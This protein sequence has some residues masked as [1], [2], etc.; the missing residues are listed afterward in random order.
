M[1]RMYQGVTRMNTVE[2]SQKS[3]RGM[4]RAILAGGLV[5]GVG[6]A[7]TLA[8]W[9]DSEFATGT[10]TAGSFNVQGT[11]G[12]PAATPTWADHATSAT[13]Q[14]LTFSL[15]LTN[16]TPGDTVYAPFSMRVDTTKNS[17]DATVVPGSTPVAITGVLATDLTTVT[18]VSSYGN[19]TAK[20][21][22]STIFST[23]TLAK[24]GAAQTLCLAVTMNADAT[25]AAQGQ[26]A[27]ATWQFDATSVPTS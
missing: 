15:N 24:A 12:D 1:I 18:Y 19:C 9:N 11:G 2:R 17:F 23:L 7:I 3:R 10:F 8:T 4:I 27:T 22:G 13:A 6:A 5:L 21:P 20:T 14:A 26:S 16:L 25:A